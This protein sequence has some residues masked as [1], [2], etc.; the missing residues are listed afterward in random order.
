MTTGGG[1]GFR[2][3]SSA[4][5]ERPGL[6]AALGKATATI[7]E[8]RERAVE[9]VPEWE[10]LRERARRI[11][12]DCL[13]RLDE[14]LERFERELASRG[15]HVHWAEDAR[16][17]CGVVLELARRAG[18]GAIAKSK[19]MVTEE[20][21][22]NEA[23]EAEGWQPLETDLGERIVQL[24]GEAPSHIIV[25]AIHMSR[26]EIAD[27]FVR[28]LGI[29]RTD[30]PAALTAVARRLLRERFESASLGISGVNFGVA[31]SGSILVLEN[32]GNIRMVSA[33]PRIHVA[34]M[35]IEKL[36]PRLE[37]LAVF[38]R[39][40]PRSGTGQRLTSYQSLLTGASSDQEGPQEMHV[41]L[42]DNGRSAMLAD[43]RE[44][45][46]LACIRCGACLNVC[47]VYKQIGGHAYGSVYPGPIGAIF[48]PLAERGVGPNSSELPYASSL[49]GAC[50]DVCPVK[51]D[52]PDV[53]LHLREKAVRAAAERGERRLE[54]RL[55]KLWARTMERPGRYRRAGALARRLQGLA[56]GRGTLSRTV[57]GRLGALA[58][59]TADREPKPLARRS[60]R[61]L[62]KDGLES[63]GGR[64]D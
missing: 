40:L 47:P 45:Q 52:I 21:G 14:H 4:A 27:L 33:L 57:A 34:V 62:W 56:L 28:E 6:R 31:E 5:L 50:R 36:V 58:A 53:L 20:I 41:V 63:E 30:D 60:F 59:W 26:A 46:T 18:P 49:C 9:G 32:E 17:A 22:L 19:S 54:R 39:L 51:I 16:E 24:A 12:A 10:R 44:R 7:G 11:K 29:E 43:E 25:P 1:D 23:L 13:A 42:V 35:G 48:T 8:R 3:R 64:R 15:V 61:E 55:F 2:A 37:D 38:L